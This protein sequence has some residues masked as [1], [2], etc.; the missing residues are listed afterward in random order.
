MCQWIKIYRHAPYR[1]L[2]PLSIV[3]KPGELISLDFIIGLPL[4]KYK[5]KVYNAI[6]VVVDACMKYNLYIPCM[7]NI[8][9]LQLVDKIL[10]EVFFLFSA[11]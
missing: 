8:K 3:S 4:S 5:G 9:T 2:Q 6:L 11:L 10:Y 7:K 1:E